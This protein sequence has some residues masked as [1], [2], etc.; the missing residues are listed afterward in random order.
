MLYFRSLLLLLFT[1][2]ALASQPARGDEYPKVTPR[3]LLLA[4]YALV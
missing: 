1:I 2:F 3:P 4:L